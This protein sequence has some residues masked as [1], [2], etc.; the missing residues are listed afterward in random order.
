M[1]GRFQGE[2]RLA[3]AARPG[4]REQPHVPSTQETRHLC[5]LPFPTD[6]RGGRHRHRGLGEGRG[7]I[8][9]VAPLRY[10]RQERSALV[11][12]EFQ[13]VRERAHGVR[14]GAPAR[15]AL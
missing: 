13:C 15:A 3:D 7:I 12:G 1:P 9:D 10:G 2:A 8:G 11:L 4:E 6:K 14:V 5:Q